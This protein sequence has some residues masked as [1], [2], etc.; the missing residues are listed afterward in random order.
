MNS[1]T[2]TTQSAWRAGCSLHVCYITTEARGRPSALP[3]VDMSRSALV[4]S[5]VTDYGPLRFRTC[6]ASMRR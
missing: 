5:I 6:T 3:T 1:G 2:G 4:E